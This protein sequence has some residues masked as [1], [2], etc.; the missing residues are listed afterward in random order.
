MISSRE[1]FSYFSLL[2][3]IWLKSNAP[4]MPMLRGE[5]A[6]RPFLFEEAALL[7]RLRGDRVHPK[8]I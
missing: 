3:T 1:K 4:G 6:K 5:S 2:W 8:L 7:K